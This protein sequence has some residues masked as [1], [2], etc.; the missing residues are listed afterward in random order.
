MHCCFIII[1]VVIVV[2]FCWCLELQGKGNICQTWVSIKC[3]VM[4]GEFWQAVCSKEIRLFTCFSLRW[5]LVIWLL[6]WTI[7]VQ[8]CMEYSCEPCPK[9][10]LSLL[11]HYWEFLC[12]VDFGLL[13]SLCLIHRFKIFYTWLILAA[14]G[15]I[16]TLASSIFVC[17]STF[18]FSNF[19]M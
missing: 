4:G 8:I 16:Y 6:T 14:R 5:H 15:H 17:L 9:V 10:F 13:M 12:L 19:T 3:R 7:N 11:T 1:V 18:Q 2:L